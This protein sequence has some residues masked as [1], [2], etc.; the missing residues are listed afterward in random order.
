MQSSLF[1]K[2]VAKNEGRGLQTP[3]PQ[4]SMRCRTRALRCEEERPEGLMHQCNIKEGHTGM[5]LMYCHSCA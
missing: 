5:A 1:L 4:Y 3:P 2:L